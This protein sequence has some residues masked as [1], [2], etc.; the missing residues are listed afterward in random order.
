[1][2]NMVSLVELKKAFEG[3]R[4]F[5]TGHT[6]FKGSWMLKIFNMIGAQVK[7]YSLAPK[8][9]DDLY[10][11]IDGDNLCV[12]I[13]ADIRDKIKLEHEILSFEPDFIFHLA[14]QPLVRESYKKPI[15]TFE[16]NALGTANLLDSLRNLQKKCSV[17]MITTDKVYYN[18]EWE[19]PYRETDRLG[20]YD[21]YSS[22]K[23]C[24]ELII[25]SYRNSF[26]NLSDI[27]SH[28]KGIAVARAGN[29]IGGGDWSTDR[30]IPDIIRSLIENKPI[31]IRNPFAVRPWQHVLEP[32][33]GYLHLGKELANKP[34][35]FSEAF[36][37]GPNPE[38]FLSVE[39]IA[40]F[41]VQYWGFGDIV[42]ERN[43][44]QPHEA[45]VLKL[46]IN[47]V[48]SRLNWSPKLNS[49]D[50]LSLTIEWYKEFAVNPSASVELI[51]NQIDRFLN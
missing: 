48:R 22:S 16:V 13:I 9:E 36:N 42:I 39:D 50:T 8:C 18:Y 10:N 2:E 19:Y 31:T 37:F 6:G 47:K 24:A 20:G 34:H 7:G 35:Q 25:E 41:A 3:K 45:K 11:L 23:A 4:V 1:M 44:K 30:L 40:R 17:V 28:N 14:A 51:K 5:L 15:D 33:L 32:I 29:V 27:S 49:E 26:F 46:D 38:S 43:Q 12:S 21:P